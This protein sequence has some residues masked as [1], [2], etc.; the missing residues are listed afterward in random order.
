MA[1]ASRGGTRNR[2]RNSRQLTIRE[3]KKA[4]CVHE[5]IQPQGPSE[6][7]ADGTGWSTKMSCPT[8]S[9]W[10]IHETPNALLAADPERDALAAAP[11]A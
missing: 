1:N 7:R 10:Y 5:K 8:C 11:V 6:M 9:A 4:I 3:I 2:S